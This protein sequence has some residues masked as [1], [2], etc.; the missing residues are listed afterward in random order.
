MQWTPRAPCRKGW[1]YCDAERGLEQGAKKALES[2][3][4]GACP[5]AE[6]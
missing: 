5:F 2:P 3:D 1:T 4:G 6:Q